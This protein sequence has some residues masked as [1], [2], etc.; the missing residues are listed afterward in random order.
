MVR[1]EVIKQGGRNPLVFKLIV[2]SCFYQK[3]PKTCTLQSFM[4]PISQSERAEEPQTYLQF[5]GSLEP[6]S[7]P[8]ACRV[9][10]VASAGINLYCSLF[11]VRHPPCGSIDKAEMRLHMISCC[12]EHRITRTSTFRSLLALDKMF[13]TMG[14]IIT[15]GQWMH[16]PVLG[17]F[18]LNSY[19]SS[20]RLK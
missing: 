9:N 2:W 7:G 14:T 6:S 15:A 10:R 19:V 3:A 4:N 12:I 13:C 18:L 5:V 8:I 17:R 20:I 11:S 16:F 1:F